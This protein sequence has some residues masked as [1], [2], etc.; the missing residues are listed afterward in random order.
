MINQLTGIVKSVENHAIHLAVGPMGFALQVPNGMEFSIGK[1]ALV[2]IYMHWN[3]ESGPSFY[4]FK[5]VLDK[6]VF[7]LVIS[8]SGIG[9]KIGLAVLG[10]LGASG[11][12]SAVQMD[13]AKT[14][15]K[16][17]GIGVKKAEQI[18]FQLRSKV[19][20]LISSGVQLGG[21]SAALEQWNTVLQAL[22]SL[23]YSRSEISH[24]MG[25]LKK[26]APQGAT[27]D[28]LMRKALNLLAK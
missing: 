28:Q 6:Q 16:V 11:F 3:S 4:G 5:E 24:A 22:E 8:C 15:S 27:F 12:V 20:K 18:V 21:N 17:N 13:S 23:N 19:E 10:D 7:E 14:L 9:P 25:Q 26:D 2:H 1:Q